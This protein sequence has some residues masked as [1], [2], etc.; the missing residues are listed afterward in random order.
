MAERGGDL[1]TGSEVVAI[2][3]APT[4]SSCSTRPRRVVTGELLVNCAGLH[5]DRVARMA[6]LTPSV[7]IVPFRG[8]YYELDPSGRDLVHGLIYP[9]PDQSSRSSG[10]T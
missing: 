3:A 5:S 1:R 10:S 7:R 8:E 9:V 6:G 4:E 2:E